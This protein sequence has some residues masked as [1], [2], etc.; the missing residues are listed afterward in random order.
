MI[1]T[2]LLAAGF[3]SVQWDAVVHPQL[4]GYRVYWG[5]TSRFTENFPGYTNA[6]DTTLTMFR[7]E[8]LDPTKTYCIAVKAKANLWNGPAESVEFSNEVCGIPKVDEHLGPP[9]IGRAEVV[10]SRVERGG[11]ILISWLPCEGACWSEP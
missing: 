4:T 11:A 2:L 9:S 7:I 8:G 6:T 5:E 3:I 1:A 10:V